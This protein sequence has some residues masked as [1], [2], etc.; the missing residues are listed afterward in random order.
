VDTWRTDRQ[1]SERGVSSVQFLL[2]AALGLV[3]FL[4]L[5]NLIVVQYG[6][7]AVRSALDQGARAGSVSGAE[8]DCTATAGDVLDQLLGGRMSSDVIITCT[9]VAGSMR[10]HASGVFEGWTAASPDYTF[11]LVSEATIEFLP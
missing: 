11:D 10:A 5:A 3:L 1:L 7:G 9:V 8:G 6:R 4:T 2:A